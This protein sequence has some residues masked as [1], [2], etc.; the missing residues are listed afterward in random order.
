MFLDKDTL[1]LARALIYDGSWNGIENKETD[2]VRLA[3]QVV[4]NLPFPCENIKLYINNTIFDEDMRQAVTEQVLD[5]LLIA[6]VGNA[7]TPGAWRRCR[8]SFQWG[9][10][11]FYGSGGIDMLHNHPTFQELYYTLKVAAALNVSVQSLINACN[12]WEDGDELYVRIESGRLMW[13]KLPFQDAHKAASWHAVDVGAAAAANWELAD[14]ASACGRAED[15]SE[16]QPFYN[17][18]GPMAEVIAAG[19]DR[20]AALTRGL[21]VFPYGAYCDACRLAEQPALEEKYYGFRMEDACSDAYMC[22][23]AYKGCVEGVPWE[24]VYDWVEEA[25]GFGAVGRLFAKIK[26]QRA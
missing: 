14:F 26:L 24:Q 25:L 11:E 17:A 20:K 3:K 15:S 9:A 7:D 23:A 21:Q 18:I 10:H 2:E 6:H 4:R 13:A 12:A 16:M 8:E 1:A 19:G 5:L 22:V